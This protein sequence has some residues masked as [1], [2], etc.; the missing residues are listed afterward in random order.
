M[1]TNYLAVM[2]IVLLLG[3]ATHLAAQMTSREQETA[4]KEIT[5]AAGTIFKN[6]QNMDAEALY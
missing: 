3:C 4:K 2:L 5:E 1:K 6:L